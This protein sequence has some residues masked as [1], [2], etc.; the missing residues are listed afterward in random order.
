V[1]IQQGKAAV[2]P[3][4]PEHFSPQE[5]G[6]RVKPGQVAVAPWR[7]DLSALAGYGYTADEITVFEQAMYG[8]AAERQL[9]GEVH[10]FGPGIG[11]ALGKRHERPGPQE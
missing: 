6:A 9:T 4:P 1:N 10:I 8:L 5:L 11:L 2:L 3:S 7:V